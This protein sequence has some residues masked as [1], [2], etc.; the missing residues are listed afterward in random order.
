MS[1]SG[2]FGETQEFED[3]SKFNLQII[4]AKGG[5]PS[6]QEDDSLSKKMASGFKSKKAKK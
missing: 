2:E 4:K 1:G 5:A 3:T 6:Y